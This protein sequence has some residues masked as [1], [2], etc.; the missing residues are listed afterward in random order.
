MQVS[1]TLRS[2]PP[3]IF[4]VINPTVF[5]GIQPTAPAANPTDANWNVPNTVVQSL[6]GRLPPGGLANGTT[7]RPAARQRRHMIF[8][9]SRRN[10]VDMRFAKVLRIQRPG[11]LDLGL[12]LQNLLIANYADGPTNSSMTTPPRMAE[13]GA[14]R[15]RS[16]GRGSRAST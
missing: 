2:Q 9:D 3:V 7:R 11:R 6:L 13:R 1:A 14:T 10:Q 16:S 15:R 12:D 4:S 8:G 5:V